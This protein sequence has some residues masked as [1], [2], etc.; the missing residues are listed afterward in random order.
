MLSRKLNSFYG[1]LVSE[2]GLAMVAAQEMNRESTIAH[3]QQVYN[4]LEAS[5]ELHYGIEVFRWGATQFSQW[6]DRHQ[7]Q[8]AAAALSRLVTETSNA[9]AVAGLAH[10]L[11][12]SLLLEGQS[13]KAVQQFEQAVEVLDNG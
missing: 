2:F 7:V 13:L 11:G 5:D 9:E 4:A 10:G 1:L 8:E 6:G 12:E 3:W